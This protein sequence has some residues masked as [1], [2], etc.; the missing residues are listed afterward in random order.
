MNKERVRFMFNLAALVIF[1][2]Y[3]ISVAT[4]LLIAFFN[5]RLEDDF[6]F[7]MTINI[8]LWG[9]ITVLVSVLLLMLIKL[10]ILRD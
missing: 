9:G 4:I 8:A 5:K 1:I 3:L 10:A 6:V 7:S 2:L